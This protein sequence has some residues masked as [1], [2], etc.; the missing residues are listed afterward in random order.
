MDDNCREVL[1]ELQVFLDGECPTDVEAVVARHLARCS[2]CLDR[3]DFERELRVI[4]ARHCR[5]V[6]PAGL[7]DRVIAQLDA[8]SSSD[9]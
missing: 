8:H 2:R 5:Q 4:L 7:L 1:T 9:R 3:A 6:A